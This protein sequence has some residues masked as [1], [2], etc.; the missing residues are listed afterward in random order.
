MIL[1]AIIAAT[2]ERV[3]R[4]PEDAEETVE[5]PRAATGFYDA[6][7]RTKRTNAIIAEIKAASP[8]R[9][10]ICS[11][12]DPRGFALSMVSS[13]CAALSVITEPRFFHGSDTFLPAVRN[14]V[15]VPILRKDFVIDPR[16][17]AASRAL[18]ADAVLLITAVLKDR[19]PDFVELAR[20][21]SL[22]P[23]VEVHTGREL[24]VALSSGTRMIGINNRNL[25]D[26]SVDLSVTKRLAPRA[27]DCGCRV[28][29]ESGFVWPC[30]VRRFRDIV[31]GFL[32]GSSIVSARNP[33]KKLEGFLFA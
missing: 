21:Y 24:E 1:D 14:A 12:I 27:R 23:L 32:I 7:R 6:V 26:M 3:A 10:I 25:K 11:D 16:Q 29:S 19:L 17:V 31:D 33:Q 8:S 5:A 13:G 28:V 2:A 30:D 22:E 20:S 9:G 4:M 18:G 15:S